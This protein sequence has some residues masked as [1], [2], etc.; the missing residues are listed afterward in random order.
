MSK[1]T[2]RKSNRKLM[3]GLMVAPPGGDK[4]VE[5]SRCGIEI[6]LDLSF[7]L[8]GMLYFN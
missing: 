4:L 3:C 2:K 7:D 1:K 6:K 8:R 5:T